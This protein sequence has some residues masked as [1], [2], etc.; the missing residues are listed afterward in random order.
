MK[1]SRQQVFDYVI[2]QRLVSAAEVSQAL[3][4]T[5]A[6]ARHHL[7]ILEAQGL[8]RVS[9][10]RQ[11]S[12]RGRPVQLYSPSEASLG[13]NLERLARA[14]LEVL[15][16]TASVGGHETHLHA[17]AHRMAVA[18]GQS[19]GARRGQ[20]GLLR[21]NPDQRQDQPKASLTQRLYQ[22]IVQLNSMHYQAHW[23]A[24]PDAP[25]IT[26]GH[27]PY[28]ALA[29]VYPQ[30]CQIDHMFIEELLG[31]PVQQT[32]RLAPDGRG[33]PYCLFTLLVR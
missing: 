1:T 7:G 13:H 25:Q 4:M 30:V 31:Q 20:N 18:A 15:L 3:Q 28:A 2:A 23:E 16:E 14:L 9:G 6:N 32:A 10:V 24:R 33:L 11:V 27:C 8:V 21:A 12:S 22:T 26:L 17:A 5:Q 19:Q 29:E